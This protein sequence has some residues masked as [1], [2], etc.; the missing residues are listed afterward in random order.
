MSVGLITTSE[1]CANPTFKNNKKKVMSKP[2]FNI[3]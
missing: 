2:S 3:T 1:F